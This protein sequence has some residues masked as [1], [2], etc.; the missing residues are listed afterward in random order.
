MIV[1]KTPLHIAALRGHVDIAAV[2]IDKGADVNIEGSIHSET[3]LHR[4]AS[5]G[6]IEMVKFL[7]QSW[8][9]C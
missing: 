8:G 2:L 7:T 5:G 4:A 1:S 6:H 3:P 9:R